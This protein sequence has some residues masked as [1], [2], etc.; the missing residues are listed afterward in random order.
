MT[1]MQSSILGLI[2]VASV[3]LFAMASSEEENEQSGALQV[4]IVQD[5]LITE[6]S[7][8]AASRTMKNAVW[9]HNDSGDKPRIF[10]VD[11]DG[12]TRA[13]VNVNNVTA[14][15]WEDMCSFE[16]DGD[17][18]LLIGDIGDNGRVRGAKSPHCQLLLL[19]EPRPAG[20]DHSKNVMETT[21]EVVR[22]ISFELPEG[23]ENCES[24]TVDSA[25]RTIFLVTKTDPL[26]SALYSLP[27][28]LTR[29]KEHLKA[30]KQ[31]S[32]AVPYAT[33]MDISPDGRH[34][35]VIDMFSGAMITRADPQSESWADACRNPVA[36]LI[37]PKR[38]QGE[39]VC[40]TADGKSLLMNS[41]GVSQPLW[42]MDNPLFQL[43]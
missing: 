24:L 37:L 39:T 15:D 43:Q 11:L 16:L 32:L 8:I 21:V 18:W 25:S 17:S 7:G 1:S 35:V 9:M 22:T 29:G 41:E 38:K 30:E 42:Q 14:T 13:I 33:A 40:F 34:L 28:T 12:T 2:F 31:A 27:L 36:V 6:A 10:L 19:K 26:H 23:P 20:I 4:C 5:P 3:L